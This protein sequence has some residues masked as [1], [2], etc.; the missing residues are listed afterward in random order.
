MS[1]ALIT[2]GAKRLGA[3]MALYLSKKGYAIAVHYNNSSDDAQKLVEK[4]NANGGRAIAIQGDLCER[5][6]QATLVQN[7]ARTLG[8]PFNCLINNASYFEFDR[9]EDGGYESFDRNMRT[10]LEA[11]FFL[12]QAFAAQCEGE[13][14]VINMIDQRVLRLTPN[15]ASYTLAKS[16]LLTMTKTAA[17]AL[18]PNIRVNGIGPGTTLQGEHQTD[19]NF[20]HHRK[21]SILEQ[22]A[23]TPDILSAL[24]YLMNA[25]NVTGQMIAVDGGQ[26]LIW[27]LPT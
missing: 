19:E 18:A 23:D 8:Q 9:I 3:A 6:V 15:F 4:I 20:A 12:T 11:P 2:G 21:I 7:A 14:Q 16:A 13:G 5:N 27:E 25:K 17:M 26:H 24:D 10:N 1:A 22:G